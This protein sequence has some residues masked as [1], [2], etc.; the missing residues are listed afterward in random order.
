MTK[1]SALA[2]LALLI[3]IGALGLGVYHIFFAV[4]VAPT[5]EASG[6]KNT[7][8]QSTIGTS[9]YTNP[10]FTYIPI[11]DLIINFT[12]SSGESVYFL[13]NAEA[14]VQSGPFRWIYFYFELDGVRLEEPTYPEW[15]LSSYNARVSAPISCQLSLDSVSAGAHNATIIIRGNDNVNYIYTSILL[16][17]TYIP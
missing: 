10:A 7:W 11:D 1:S 2:V 16:I 5:E 6:I 15:S 17:Q 3:A 9:Y 8:Y 12:V 4:P 13:F 14:T